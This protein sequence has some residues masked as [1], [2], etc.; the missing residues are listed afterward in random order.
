[1]LLTKPRMQA[2]LIVITFP[3]HNGEKTESNNEYLV[4]YFPDGTILLVPKLSDPFE[5]D[6]EGEFYELDECEDISP[7]RRELM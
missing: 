3:P 2:S 1:M 4:V 5:V 7:D 6:D